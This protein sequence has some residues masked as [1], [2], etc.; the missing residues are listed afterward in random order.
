MGSNSF[1]FAVSLYV[2][3]ETYDTGKLP[4]IPNFDYNLS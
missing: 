1:Y 2:F 4:F 3:D